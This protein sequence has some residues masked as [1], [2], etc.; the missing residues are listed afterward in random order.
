MRLHA[1][2]RKR[3]MQEIVSEACGLIHHDAGVRSVHIVGGHRPNYE[4]LRRY[5][6]SATDDH[7]KLS[8]DREGVITITPGASWC[9]KD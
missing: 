1:R 2:P 8:V 9:E 6:K 3:Q 5:R 4:Q 7:V